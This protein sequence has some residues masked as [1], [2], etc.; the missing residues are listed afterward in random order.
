MVH[1]TVW[2]PPGF[3]E[4]TSDIEVDPST[5]VSSVIQEVSK[6]LDCL[7][8]LE[9]DLFFADSPSR[10]WMDCDKAL[11][12]YSIGEQ[13][14]K[15]VVVELKSRYQRIYVWHVYNAGNKVVG[16]YVLMNVRRPLSAFLRYIRKAFSLK[17][18]IAKYQLINRATM[19]LLP[20]DKSLADLDIPLPF[21]VLVAQ[22]GTPMSKESIDALQSVEDVFN[23]WSKLSKSAYLDKKKRW[24]VY[25]RG[26]LL[27]Y[28]NSEEE[29]QG[30][31]LECI[32]LTEFCLS[33]DRK[34]CL[35]ELTGTE[36]PKETHSL[37]FNTEE[38]TDVWVSCLK[39][40]CQD[41]ESIPR[42]ASKCEV[43]PLYFGAPI[44]KVKPPEQDVPYLVRRCIEWL[45]EHALDVEGIFRLSG[46]Q[47]EINAIKA[48]YNE[49]EMV[50]VEEISDVHTVAGLLKCYFRDLPEPLLK[51]EHYEAFLQAQ[52]EKDPNKRMHVLREL[53]KQLPT[54]NQKTLKYLIEFLSC[55]EKHSKQNKMALHNLATVFA[56]N[57]I[58][59]REKDDVIRTVQDTPLVNGLVSTLIRDYEWI[60]SEREEMVTSA[61][62]AT[63]SYTAQNPNQLSFEVDDILNVYNPRVGEDAWWYGEL[64]GEFGLFPSDHVQLLTNRKQQFLAEMQQVQERVT[65]NAKQIECLEARK[66]QLVS[67]IKTLRALDK[68]TRRETKKVNSVIS[69]MLNDETNSVYGIQFQIDQLLAHFSSYGKKKKS[70][71][72]MKLEMVEEV[73]CVK[74][75]LMSDTK[76]R[77]VKDKGINIID[78]LLDKLDQEQQLR[79]K[80]NLENK[81]LNRS[82]KRIKLY[83]SCLDDA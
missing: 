82:L 62:K 9:C 77:K 56:P 33:S 68:I 1:L 21:E 26:K 13:R 6:K 7:S 80:V 47:N 58:H 59:V 16:G 44:E 66:A 57:L 61:A 32:D 60:F 34:K 49:G 28:K 2:L 46:S 48:R 78:T 18:E 67:E 39:R 5:S 76:Y 10:K 23:S 3:S 24:L 40:V 74:K 35:I 41:E 79:V 30:K 73:T 70:V 75:L 36:S 50:D 53:I 52:E 22:E 65:D 63:Q 14:D 81:L 64:N 37:K 31:P 29:E 72:E 17:Y 25:E 12:D 69:S 11:S 71:Q 55:V 42:G 27:S 51:Y 20:E 15:D 4:K 8:W 54:V 38:D 19:S 43:S 45:R 83:F